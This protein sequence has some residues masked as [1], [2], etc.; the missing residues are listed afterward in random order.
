GRLVARGLERTLG[1]VEDAPHLPRERTGERVGLP[2]GWHEHLPSVHDPIEQAPA[3]AARPRRSRAFL[4]QQVP[5]RA[6]AP[7]LLPCVERRGPTAR[8]AD[9]AVGSHLR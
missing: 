4:S 7:I 6:G 8:P 2:A 1:P 5:A 9:A 3:E